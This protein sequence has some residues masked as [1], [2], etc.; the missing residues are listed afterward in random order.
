MIK[1]VI[2]RPWHDAI[3]VTAKQIFDSYYNKGLFNKKLAEIIFKPLLEAKELSINVTLQEFY[4]YSNI[5]LHI[6]TFELN[7]FETIELSAYNSPN[8]RV[9][10]SINNVFIFAWYIYAHNTRR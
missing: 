2:E 3:K 5:D 4:E 6:F 1:Y 7:K 10:G 8:I 9:V